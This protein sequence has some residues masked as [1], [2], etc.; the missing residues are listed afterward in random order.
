MG[1]IE[2]FSPSLSDSA[3]HGLWSLWDMLIL[4]AK[5]FVELL[6]VLRSAE[7]EAQDKIGQISPKAIEINNEGIQETIRRLAAL[8]LPVSITNCRADANQL[9]GFGAVPRG[10]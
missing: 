1:K 7:A 8:D 9:Q 3:S 2:R 5:E 10:Y 6:Q 4:D